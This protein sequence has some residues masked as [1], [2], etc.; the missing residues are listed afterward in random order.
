MIHF[1]T[2]ECGKLP[3][4]LNREKTRV[5]KQGQQQE[6]TGIVVNEKTQLPESERK[7]IRQEIY[8][9]RRYGLESHLQHRLATGKESHLQEA[10]GNGKKS[11]LRDTGASQ[12]LNKERYLSRLLGRIS[13]ALFINPGDEAMRKYKETVIEWMKTDIIK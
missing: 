4:K 7:K 1:V 3:T 8:Y 13:Y 10:P 11:R 2:A 12:D 9:I 6:V 5:R